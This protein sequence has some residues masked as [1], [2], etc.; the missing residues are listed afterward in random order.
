MAERRMFAKSIIDS[1]SFMNMPFSAQALYFQLS[2]RADDDGFLNNTQMILRMTGA[3]NDDLK[4]LADK[5]FIIIFESGAVA[6]THWKVHNYIRKDTYKATICSK[7]KAT[8]F[9]DENKAYTSDCKQAVDEP[10]TQDSIV[11]DST[12]KNSTDKVNFSVPSADEVKEYCNERN[13]NIDAEKFIDYYSANGWMVGK[14]KMKDWKAA[15]R[16]WERNNK[17]EN[18]A[19]KIVTPSKFCNFAQGSSDFDEIRKKKR[20]AMIEKAQKTAH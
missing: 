4:L 15:I 5:N 9:F 20:M 14:N 19:Q 7:E 13:N 6:V 11:E 2:L 16:S 17:K 18:P 1:D 12:D 10:S 8:L 3:G